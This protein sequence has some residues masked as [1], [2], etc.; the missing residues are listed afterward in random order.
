MT[1]NDATKTI[2]NDELSNEASPPQSAGIA[3]PDL[4]DLLSGQA[5]VT[6]SM[7]APALNGNPQPSLAGR[8]STYK[9]PLPEIDE[10]SY[11]DFAC[12]GTPASLINLQYVKDEAFRQ[13]IE[14]RNRQ[15]NGEDNDKSP[16]DTR[17][18]DAQA[19]LALIMRKNF[20]PLAEKMK[21]AFDP[22]RGANGEVMLD[23]FGIPIPS[24]LFRIMPYKG[25]IEDLSFLALAHDNK[26][27]D[28]SKD[29]K[30][31]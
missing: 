16:E 22:R 26:N 30:K 31:K 27:K 12:P 15:Q 11:L 29:K 9:P 13:E 17:I 25:G 3:V 28:K 2:G 7:V 21:H 18:I 5:D 23:P 6:D 24:P 19:R 10:L 4:R 14:R 20:K 1:I 8:E